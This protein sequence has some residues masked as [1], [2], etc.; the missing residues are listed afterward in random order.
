[1]SDSG[2]PQLKVRP[3]VDASRLVLGD[4]TSASFTPSH[5]P[6]TANVDVPALHRKIVERFSR[7]EIGQ[8]CM[9]LEDKLRAQGIEES[10]SIDIIGGQGTP[11][12]ARNLIS[13]L[14]R[15]G[16]LPYLVELVR[17]HR[18]GS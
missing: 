11:E 1:L 18:P 12:I 14:Q 5:T 15:R 9:E 4:A 7:D 13:H 17:G 16:L 3:G 6:G 10:I 2:R 8:L